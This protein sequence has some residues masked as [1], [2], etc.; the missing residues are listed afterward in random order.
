MVLEE[1]LFKTNIF[2]YE[3]YIFTV[4]FFCLA[5]KKNKKNTKNK[6]KRKQ[7][8]NAKKKE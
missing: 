4:H 7:K 3:N 1:L 6:K 2:L 8:K 5:Q